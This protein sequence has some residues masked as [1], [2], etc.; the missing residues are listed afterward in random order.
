M[1]P[2]ATRI[3]R[4]LGWRLI[5]AG[6]L[7]MCAALAIV[8]PHVCP[9]QEPLPSG[10]KQWLPAPYSFLRADAAATPPAR[11]MPAETVAYSYQPLSPAAPYPIKAIDQ[12]EH[13]CPVGWSAARTMVWQPYAQGEYTGHERL[14]HVPEYR[15]RVDDVLELVFRV[16]R[17]QTSR[18]YLLNVG[19]EVKIESSADTTLDRTLVVQPDGS[20]TLR[21]LGQVKATRHTVPQLRDDIEELYKKYYPNPAI[22]VTPIKVNTKLEDLRATV[23][24]R[25]GLGGQSRQARVTPEGSIALPAVGS[26]PAQGLT[27]GELKRE[28]DERFATKV[29]GLEVTPILLSRAPRFIYVLGEVGRPGRVSL[30][31]PTT[32][33]QA[34]SLAGGWNV[35][36]NMRQVIVFRRGD[37]WRLM[38]TKLDI[39][40]PLYAKTPTPADEIWLNDSD[41]VVVPK[42]PIK[43]WND[44]VSLGATQGIYKVIPFQQFVTFNMLSTIP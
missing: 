37:D 3:R 19:D 31:G 39:R 40:G 28:L 2:A 12:T 20:I 1:R 18:P 41:V 14:R 30:E 24:R 27:L 4:S 33:M 7:A 11:Q 21:L 26:V 29:E 25:F 15:L 35:G 17:N 38:A 23:D 43:V 42:A 32:A 9:G 8:Q 44:Y 22:T 16:T 6:L 13:Y 36:G 34:I 5:S 10:P